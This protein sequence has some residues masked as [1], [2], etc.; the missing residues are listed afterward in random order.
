[1]DH[2]ANNHNQE[3][4]D[5]PV[6]IEVSKPAKSRF[7]FVLGFFTLFL[8][9]WASCYGVYTHSYKSNADVKVPESSL[10]SPKYK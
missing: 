3:L 4:I 10:Y 7:L 9:F 1:M 2:K 6:D 5:H 8:F